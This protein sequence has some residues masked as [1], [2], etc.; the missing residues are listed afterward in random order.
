MSIR[1][2]NMRAD[3]LRPDNVGGTFDI[4]LSKDTLNHLRPDLVEKALEA[5]KRVSH[6]DL[7]VCNS[8]P[9][10]GRGKPVTRPLGYSY[11]WS[12]YDYCAFGLRLERLLAEDVGTGRCNKSEKCFLFHL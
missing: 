1:V 4:I 11:A 3:E 12:R 5:F 10:Q 9:G 8:H 7:L 2:I 6:R